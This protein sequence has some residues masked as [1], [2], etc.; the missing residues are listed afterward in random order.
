ME[1]GIRPNE[2]CSAKGKKEEKK[3]SLLMSR[4]KRTFDQIEN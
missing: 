3:I 1:V 4:F 2:G